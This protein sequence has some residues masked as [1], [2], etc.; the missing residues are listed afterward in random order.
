MFPPVNFNK[1]I[2]QRWISKVEIIEDWKISKSHKFGCNI[3]EVI[4]IER[5]INEIQIIIGCVINSI[6]PI[7]YPKN[8]IS[9]G[10]RV[11]VICEELERDEDIFVG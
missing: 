11:V 6:T 4:K 9:G 8:K 1:T 5:L 10:K 2:V 7:K 3:F